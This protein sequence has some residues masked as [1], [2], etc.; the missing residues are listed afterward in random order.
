MMVN[1]AFYNVIC[2]HL[3]GVSCLVV[4]HQGIVFLLISNTSGLSSSQVEVNRLC[5]RT[6]SLLLLRQTRVPE[7]SLTAST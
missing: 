4:A 6:P 2:C 7:C 5:P 3:D 1:G